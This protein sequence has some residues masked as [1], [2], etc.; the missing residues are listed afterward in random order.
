MPCAVKLIYKYSEIDVYNWPICRSLR[1]STMRKKQCFIQQALYLIRKHKLWSPGVWE[2]WSVS[3][4][5]VIMIETVPLVMQSW[6]IFRLILLSSFPCFRKGRFNSVCI[7][8][9]WLNSHKV[10]NKFLWSCNILSLRFVKV[11]II[12]VNRS[13]V[14]ILHYNLL[15]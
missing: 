2:P 1:F 15:K 9:L 3:L 10:W 14:S 11:L 12:V 13:S 8:F 7:M 4:F 5:F 6:M